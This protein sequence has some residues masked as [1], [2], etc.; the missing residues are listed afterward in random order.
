MG[1]AAV[2][3]WSRCRRS[4]HGGGRQRCLVFSS[5]PALGVVFQPLRPPWSSSGSPS[6]RPTGQE[7]RVNGER[8][9]AGWRSGWGG[10]GQEEEL[11]SCKDR[12][13]LAFLS[14]Y[15]PRYILLSCLS[16][17]LLPI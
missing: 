6:H 2:V 16:V 14:P 5:S 8:T 15:S 4:T 12:Y 7:W 1:T 11:Q 9:S 13:V 3:A 17:Y 10:A